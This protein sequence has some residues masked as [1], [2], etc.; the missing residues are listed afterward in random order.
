M[1]LPPFFVIV[2]CVVAMWNIVASILLHK[3]VD[4]SRSDIDT[5]LYEKHKDDIKDFK[6]LKLLCMQLDVNS[7][8]TIPPKVFSLN[9]C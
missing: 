2:F 7:T 1:G 4:L 8:G 3:A 5:M 9:I 6:E